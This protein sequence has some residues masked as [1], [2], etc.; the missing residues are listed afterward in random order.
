MIAA[1][2]GF[3][4]RITMPIFISYS[5][6]DQK[7]AEAICTAIENRG[8]PCWISSRDIGPG[9]NF[10]TQ[11]VRAIRH[12]KIM[13]LVFSAHAN[14]SE[15]IKK[16]LVLAGQSRLVVI[17]VRVEDVTPDEAFAYEFA[18]RQWIDVFGDWEHAIGRVVHQIEAVIGEEEAEAATPKPAED[19]PAASA[20][21][22]P[23][24]APAAPAAPP[25]APTA[26]RKSPM[27]AIL[28][29][30]AVVIL[31]LAGLLVWQMWPKHG[32]PPPSASAPIGPVGT[33]Q[34]PSAPGTSSSS[35]SGPITI[36][37][38]PPPSAPQPAATPSDPLLT[39]LAS[40]S[41]AMSG[42]F[43]AD[44]VIA[45][46]DANIHKALAVPPDTPSA[47]YIAGR[48]SPESARDG[49]LELCEIEV[50]KPCVLVAV[51]D[52]PQPIPPDGKWQGQDMPRVHYEGKFDLAQ[53]PGIAPEV[54]ER[55]D[56]VGYAGLTGPKA[57]A[58]HLAG[59][60]RF[61]VGTG[62]DQHAAEADALKRCDNDERGARANF[63]ECFLYASGD[64]V[65]FSRRSR[66]PV[67]AQTTEAP[68]EPPKTF[69]DCPNCPEMV[70]VPAGSFSMGAAA[71]ENERY[72]VPMLEAGRDGPQ[73]Q[74]TF[75]KPF[76]LG[77]FD[78][79][80]GEFLEFARETGFRPREGCETVMG[81]HWV[82]Q[83]RANWEHQ[84]YPQT[85]RNPVVC[86]NDFEINAYLDWLR[87]KTGKNYRLPSEAEW[88]Y[89]ERGGTT[90]AFYWGDDPKDACKYENVGDEDYGAKYGVSNP[91][92]CKD[93]FSDLAPVGSFKPN[94]FGLY[95]MA[96]N[97]FAMTADCWNETYSGAP[98]DGSAWTS[99]D[100]LRRVVR[101]AAFGNPHVW[102]FRSA[103]RAAEGN[104]VRRNRFG[105]RVA[106]SL[107]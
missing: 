3:R 97:I 21:P 94:P 25:P 35:S 10:Q 24:A 66:E 48:P 104:I 63:R 67:T 72:E 87:H 44:H 45:Y 99:G 86:M 13:V 84:D 37:P 43:R 103:N 5:S 85:D 93:G 56:F 1:P 90:T 26:P 64:K 9:E 31:I 62:P 73:H 106:L 51:D 83:P 68:R 38:A 27:A 77:K 14:N 33:N 28:G 69:R 7:T 102:M 58:F 91:I 88:E 105:F 49:V 6:K 42:Q 23:P 52:A 71:G 78:V 36:P 74:V 17:P 50:D 4:D 81:N 98:S 46:R 18:T 40:A 82:P 89:A 57:I 70:V 65:I 79:T 55:A 8:H 96:G 76:A 53:M 32:A 2:R 59:R 75:A 80:F 100:C 92:P 101:K 54:A 11:I 12:A 30:A 20:A 16:E 29:G 39:A 22:P 15:E 107:P 47:W 34:A 41:P 95:D 19:K 60:T 61:F